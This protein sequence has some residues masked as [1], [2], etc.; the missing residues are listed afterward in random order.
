M[1]SKVLESL[2]I[3]SFDTIFTSLTVSKQETTPA[4]ALEQFIS[5]D[6]QVYIRNS[7]RL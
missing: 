1:P 2:A 4:S 3:P 6:Q 5:N 7:Q